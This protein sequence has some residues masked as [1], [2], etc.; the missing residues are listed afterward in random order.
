MTSL[1]AVIITKNEEQNIRRCLES[2][3][4]ADEIIVID[5]NST[6]K[7]KEIA[8]KQ[9]AKVFN[10]PWQGFGPAKQEGVNLATGEWILSIDADEEVPA[11]LAKEI[12]N[13]I[14]SANGISAFY[15]KRKTMFL[16]RWILYCGWYP[17][18]VLRLFQKKEGNFDNA[19]V[20][21]KVET[22]G[23]V[24]YLQSDLLHYSYPDLETY[25]SKFNRYTTLGAEE[26]FHAGKKAGWFG[27]IIK[28]PVSFLKHY[29]VRQGFRDG[30]E[31]FILSVLS[32]VAVL[33]K[34]A[35]LH[36]LHKEK[37]LK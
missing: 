15:L 2:V 32:A 33:V 29:I 4:F 24:E 8:E 6:D 14:S 1:S 21:E 23:R 9:G 3:K 13:K 10:F 18:Y 11:D 34:Y 5:S 22:K 36:T 20:H 17:G 28:P 35:K 26:A 16:G 30:L 19:V 37:S 27:I 25:F 12:V 7:T 31:G